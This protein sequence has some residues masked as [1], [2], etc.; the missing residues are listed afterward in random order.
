MALLSVSIVVLECNAI[1]WPSIAVLVSEFLENTCCV[2]VLEHFDDTPLP[3][4]YV[5][6]LQRS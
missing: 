6:V 1:T 5:F 4:L 2:T 3:A